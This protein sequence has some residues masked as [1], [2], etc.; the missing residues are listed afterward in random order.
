M[1]ELTKEDIE[2][3]RVKEVYFHFR[4]NE[5]PSL[6]PT[7]DGFYILPRGGATVCFKP[8][9]VETIPVYVV[10]VTVCSPSDMFC[11]ATGRKQ[12]LAR[13]AGD[14]K[15]HT[16]FGAGTDLK[17][18][19]ERLAWER[20]HKLAERHSNKA[21]TIRWRIAHHD[22]RL[23]AHEAWG[24]LGGSEPLLWPKQRKEPHG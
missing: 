5:R 8:V 21:E 10:G 9:V 12:S 3:G 19:A 14:P 18:M 24:L 23:L 1:K 20:W 7:G 15:L 2:S 11:K 16:T 22:P 17:R 13:T 6:D 4:R